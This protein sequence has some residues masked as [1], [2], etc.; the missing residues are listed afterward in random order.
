MQQSPRKFAQPHSK[1]AFILPCKK[2]Q[3]KGQK[4]VESRGEE[5]GGKYL[6]L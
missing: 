5:K 1:R 6:V 3:E 2:G 4:N